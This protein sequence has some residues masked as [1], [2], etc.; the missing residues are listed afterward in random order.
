MPVWRWHI[1]KLQKRTLT[2]LV[3]RKSLCPAVLI[4]SAFPE[5]TTNVCQGPAQTS[6]HQQGNI[7]Y[8]AR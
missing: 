5:E 4:P 8:D 2:Q 1:E 7:F 6:K 3:L